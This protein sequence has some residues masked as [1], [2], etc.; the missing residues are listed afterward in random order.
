M[1]RSFATWP[2]LPS[3][4][5]LPDKE[6]RWWDECYVPNT[7]MPSI[8][9]APAWYVL[10]GVSGCGKSTAL[11]AFKQRAASNALILEYSPKHL[12]GSRQ[13]L[14]SGNNLSQILALASLELRR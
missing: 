14:H 5:R 12:P 10:Y 7:H 1:L 13:T 9:D 8:S 11:A 3:Q 6:K 4:R 2:F